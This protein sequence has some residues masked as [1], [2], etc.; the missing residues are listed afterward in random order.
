MFGCCL[1]KAFSFLKGNRGRMDL[2]ER[3]SQGLLAGGKEEKL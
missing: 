3:R 2:R 1:L